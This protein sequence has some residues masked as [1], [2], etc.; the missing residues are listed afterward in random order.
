MRTV[1][2]F[3]TVV[4]LLTTGVWIAWHS[5]IENVSQNLATIEVKTNSPGPEVSVIWQTP[6]SPSKDDRIELKQ[7]QRLDIQKV[8]TKQ[9]AT[10][11]GR[12]VQQRLLIETG[13]KYER[14]VV[15]QELE[16]APT[17]VVRVR[18]EVAYA[19]GHVLIKKPADHSAEAFTNRMTGLG[20]NVVGRLG[21]TE[22]YRADTPSADIGSV[23]LALNQLNR[24]KLTAEPDY[25]CFSAEMLGETRLVRFDDTG[26]AAGLLNPV[27]GEWTPIGLQGRSHSVPP[28]RSFSLPTQQSLSVRPAG[29]RLID[30]EP[31]DGRTGGF[32]PEVRMHNFVI[33]TEGDNP[34]TAVVVQDGNG[35]NDS[36]FPNNGGN[37]VRCLSADKAMIF[38]HQDGLAFDVHSVDL[39]EYSV[40]VKYPGSVRFYGHHPDGS[41][42][43]QI[44]QLDRIMD[45]N[46]PL[47]DFETFSFGTNFQNVVSL[48]ASNAPFHMDN[49][50]V[51][52]RGLETPPPPPPAPPVLYQVDWDS[53][54]HQVDMLSAVGGYHAPTSL[55][56][57]RSV[58]RSALGPLTNRPVELKGDGILTFG[59][60]RF[61]CR[62]GAKSYTIEFDVTQT[63]AK[64]LRFSPNFIISGS[65]GLFTL[66]LGN[67]IT[68]FASGDFVSPFSP[69]SY[70]RFAVNRI[71]VNFDFESHIWTFALNGN[72]LHSGQ[73]QQSFTDLY[74]LTLAL[75]DPEGTGGTGIDNLILTAAAPTPVIHEPNLVLTPT[76]R[77][78][79]PSTSIGST[80]ARP[81]R[82]RNTG[83]TNLVIGAL[84]LDNPQFTIEAL[85]TNTIAPGK[86]VDLN[87]MFSPTQVSSSLATLTVNSNDPDSPQT[88]LELVGSGIGIPRVVISPVT[89]NVS[90]VAGTTGVENFQICND[91]TGVLTWNL[92]N[93]TSTNVPPSV[94]PDDPNYPDQW[95]LRPDDGTGD[96][97][98]IDVPGGWS[99]TTGETSVVVAVI[100]TGV[101]ID[102]PDLDDNIFS[103]DMEIPNN[104]ID[105]DQNGYVDDVNG[106]DFT[107]DDY[108]L[109]DGTGHGTHV[110]GIIGAEG[111]NGLGVS[112]V[113]WETSIL[114]IRFLGDTGSGFTSD[115]IQAVEYARD[116]GARIINASWGGSGD[117]ELLRDAIDDFT[118]QNDGIFVAAAG[119]RSSDLD[120]A[121]EFPA[122]FTSSSIVSVTATDYDD[123]LAYFSNY[124]RSAVDLAA[125]G[126]G[127]LST[128]RE[129][130]YAY[131]SGTSHAA[132]VVSGVAALALSRSPGA[133][134]ADLAGY[135]KQWVD[136]PA[137]LND[138]VATDGRLSASQA[139]NRVPEPWL[140]PVPTLGALSPGQKQT[141][142]LQVD[143]RNLTAGMYVA[144]LEF[145]T[146]DPDNPTVSLPVNLN[147]LPGDPLNQWTVDTF[148][149]QNLLFNASSVDQWSDT[150]DPDGD[151]VPNLLEYVFKTAPM[152]AS[153]GSPM[154]LSATPGGQ[155][156]ITFVTRL[157]LVGADYSLDWIGSLN[158]NT[159]RTDNLQ[160]DPVSTN[161]A[162]GTVTW[163]LRLDPTPTGQGYFRIRA[164]RP[165]IQ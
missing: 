87:V 8:L 88:T 156:E 49:L 45:G 23:T 26:K 68:L 69:V 140:L 28:I 123:D 41:V 83:S 3:F 33:Q 46:G 81:L 104:L 52:L 22:V 131:M 9:L 148:A 85:P 75:E 118:E 164:S 86:F 13:N 129:Q 72:Q 77:L 70:D 151:G 99:V 84:D 5:N 90:M 37:Y 30:F 18:R 139:L 61:E 124:G 132:P 149:D 89:L 122:S 10:K 165:Q 100:D 154:Q 145:D 43:E 109:D 114:P 62:N 14:V 111:N 95:Y 137:G 161:P 73:F 48:V 160:I 25:M 21:R 44:F 103:N 147:V 96:L 121:P 59:S 143:C 65:S 116:A 39:S 36:G 106:W 105:D 142:V 157:N 94:I 144:T 134:R 71:R 51:T 6:V 56:A 76:N 63:E 47:E 60:V 53:P 117:S 128:H 1:A 12:V 31:P 11:S 38:G 102:H 138:R 126:T 115:A 159:W 19:A 163:R 120:Q 93:N 58:V 133:S 66:Y 97:G 113:A 98:I 35:V 91:G 16:T 153:T 67:Q 82:L 110:A 42:S 50:L 15:D 80:T 150:A 155:S 7:A 112:G 54:P 32:R 2:R 20:L 74:R 127:I 17:G 119:N 125:P 92:V 79:Y 101:D 64:T 29:S 4:A 55:D 57:G 146:N 136:H 158:S 27:S 108:I 24:S 135:L 141:V 78:I 162:A 107:D 152:T 130:G 40:I 34:F